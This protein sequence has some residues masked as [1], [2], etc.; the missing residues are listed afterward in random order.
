MFKVL[1]TSRVIGTAT[2]EPIRMLEAEGCVIVENPYLG[3]NLREEE[4][5]RLVKG[6]D[7]IIV[8]ED[9]VTRRVVEHA[10]CLKVISKNGVG[11]DQ[12][13][14]NAA[15]EK[16]VVVTNTP[17]ANADAVA[18]L[19]FGLILSVARSIPVAHNAVR[20]GKWD[21]FI[22]V[23]IWRKSIGII[24]VGRI[25]KGVAKRARG[26]EMSILGYDT[27]KD[28]EFAKEV[29]LE[30]VPLEVI[31][32]EADV[33]TIHVPLTSQTQGMITRKHLKMM[34]KSAYLVNVA[35]GGIVNSMDLYDALIKE[36]LAGA[37][38]DV[39]DHEPPIGNPLLTLDNVVTT[40]HIGAFTKEA[41]NNQCRQ[42]VLNAI[43]IL[44]GRRPA[45]TVN[46]EVFK[47]ETI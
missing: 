5:L 7:A 9:S 19:T 8:G 22:G 12:I 38:L 47:E 29:G 30:Y 4:L 41:I 31:F 43:D 20:Q 26:F 33:I 3:K 40:P 28:W 36:E 14:V 35:R 1:I 37:A 42:A 27:F 10:D 15:T 16:G 17:G 11:V 13:D 23:E 44:H 32:K 2:I 18:D 21:K 6:V 45:F 39:F 46:P 24:G 25:G 34:K